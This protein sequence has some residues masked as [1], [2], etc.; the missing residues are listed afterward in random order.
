[1][2]SLKDANAN[3]PLHLATNVLRLI[4]DDV[5]KNMAKPLARATL[6]VLAGDGEMI[7]SG[8]DERDESGQDDGGPPMELDDTATADIADDDIAMADTDPSI[9]ILH[10]AAIDLAAAEHAI[11]VL[12]ESLYA[13]QP[14]R[15]INGLECEPCRIVG[16][17]RDALGDAREFLEPVRPGE[18]E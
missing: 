13:R 16:V 18:G 6:R 10:A 14:C 12:G 5:P 8:Q 9:P 15:C 2:S 17:M 4:A 11:S 1:M 3:D 7:P